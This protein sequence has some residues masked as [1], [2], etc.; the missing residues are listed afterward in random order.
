VHDSQADSGL[1]PGKS[2]ES[3]S[4]SQQAESKTSEANNAESTQTLTIPSNGSS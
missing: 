4:E 1:P 2:K 3:V